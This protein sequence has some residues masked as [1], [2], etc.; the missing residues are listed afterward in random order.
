MQRCAK[1]LPWSLAINQRSPKSMRKD[2]LVLGVALI[3]A[4]SASAAEIN[5]AQLVQQMADAYVG[6]FSRRFP[7]AATFSGLSL[8]HHD[9]LT[10]NSLTALHEWEQLEDRWQLQLQRIDIAS[11]RDTP[12]RIVYGFLK[13]AVEASR[14]LRICRNELWAVNQ[15]S[16][17]QTT[18]GQLAIAQPVGNEQARTEALS[19]WSKVPRYLANEIDN[20]REGLKQGYSTPRHNV[21]LVIS[22]LDELLAIA[23]DKSPFYDPAQRDKTP[24]FEKAWRALLTDRITPAIHRY[25]AFLKSE[26]LSKARIAIA[27]S[28]NPQGAACYQA[29]F[30]SYTTLD[31]PA[32]E[33]FDLG[34]RAVKR[35]LEAALDIGR[36]HLQAGDIE[37]L[38]RRLRE[39][40]AN[41]FSSRDE[42]LEFSR[43]AV[44]RAKTAMPKWFPNVPKS[45]IIV[46]PYPAFLERTASNSY[47]PAA[48]DG[49][50]PAMYQITLYNY[51]DTT[52]SN[53]EITAFHEAYPGHHLQIGLA[54][55]RPE[56]H[57]ITRLV[58]NSGFAEGWA[59]YAEALSEEMGLYTSDHARANRRLWPARGMVIDPGIHLFG[60]TREQAVE[61]A[62]ASGRFESKAAQSLVDRVAVWPGQLTAYDTGALEFF[63]LREEAQKTLGPNFDIR[64]FH[65]AVLHD[66]T[67]TLPMLRENVRRWIKREQR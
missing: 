28:A 19:R 53:S 10:D 29:S 42:L 17:W 67:V 31:R 46:Q 44:A 66:G 63:A 15:M 18:L 20:L 36:T 52:R 27:I 32:Q 56:A 65:D 33:T 9:G 38:L 26:Y 2:F 55:E 4:A 14:Q 35:N 60:W 49:S 21:E 30:R 58:I 6:E 47:W 16:G 7:E 57:A 24:E 39:D 40:K 1:L 25:Q 61:F 23:L 62:L 43:G 13:E 12:D 22:Q 37:T 54:S 41:R 64:R 3:A 48:E 59:R 8:P 45:D 51:A 11:L 34:Q 50:R 5:A